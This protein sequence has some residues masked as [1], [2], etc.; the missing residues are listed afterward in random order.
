MPDLQNWTSKHGRL[1]LLGDS[2]HAMYPDA[3]QGFSQ[4]VEDIAALHVLLTSDKVDN[5]S[6]ASATSAWQEL[7]KP[8]VERIKSFARSNHDLYAQGGAQFP[9]Q[10][11]LSDESSVKGRHDPASSKTGSCVRPDMWA[12][13]NTPA[14]NKWVHGYDVQAEARVSMESRCAVGECAAARCMQV[15]ARS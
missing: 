10:P 13:F 14:F 4:I 3:A 6:I 8:R 9:K 7:R 15:S 2:A 12:A 11:D 1:L 5:E